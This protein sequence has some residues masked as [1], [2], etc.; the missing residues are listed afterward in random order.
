MA[1]ASS[2]PLKASEAMSSETVNPIPATA[3][4][5]TTA[6]QPTGG[7]SLRFRQPADQPRRARRADRLA[8]DVADHDAE[9]GRRRIGV[10]EE[11]PADL[12]VRVG[13]REQRDDHVAR[14]PV[15]TLLQ[16]LVR[17]DRPAHDLARLGGQPRGGLLAEQPEGVGCLLQ[18]LARRRVGAGQQADNE[19]GDD[20]V[21]PR[22]EEGDPGGEP[23]EQVGRGVAHAA[24]A[25]DA[26]DREQRRADEQRDPADVAAVEDG[27]DRDPGEV[28]DDGEGQQVGAH[29]VG[30]PA[31]AHEGKGAERERGVGGHRR[32]PAV[33]GRLAER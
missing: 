22:L 9:R 5:P 19:A 23:D 6:P 8:G 14:P 16:P 25:H 11:R 31:A 21:D 17:R 18:V 12:D 4:T 24:L 30:Q 10:R 33:R 7:V 20:R 15:V 3:P 28:I 26:V 1:S 2:V 32:A 27:D 13:Q 29:A